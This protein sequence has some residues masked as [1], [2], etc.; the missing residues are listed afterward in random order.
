MENRY[1]RIKK[2]NNL[3]SELRNKQNEFQNQVNDIQI[4]ILDNN[5]MIQQLHMYQNI[6]LSY[7]IP[8][9]IKLNILK[10]LFISGYSSIMLA[11]IPLII[12]RNPMILVCGAAF[13]ILGTGLGAT[14][15][16]IAYK[17]NYKNIVNSLETNLKSESEIEN[18][19]QKLTEKKNNIE[20]KI[21]EIKKMYSYYSAK[22]SPYVKDNGMDLDV[23]FEEI[24]CELNNY[25]DCNIKKSNND[26]NSKTNLKNK[27]NLNSGN[28]NQTINDEEELFIEKTISLK[29]TK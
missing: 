2:A 23:A 14:I 6:K 10:W 29:I 25:I 19:N 27:I 22:L 9:E 26:N 20:I 7:D 18:D 24:F 12:I 3:L 15:E 13:T 11:I 16:T 1:D 4:Q 8:N 5:M 21:S 28:I 17:M